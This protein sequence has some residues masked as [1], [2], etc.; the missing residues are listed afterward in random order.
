[1]TT[2]HVRRYDG[3]DYSDVSQE[4]RLYGLDG[5]HTKEFFHAELGVCKMNRVLHARG[6]DK[7][8]L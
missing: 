1:M 2:E 5:M 6:L 4:T 7:D 3:E 8:E